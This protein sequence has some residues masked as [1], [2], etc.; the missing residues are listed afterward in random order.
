MGGED[1]LAVTY[2]R[3]VIQKNKELFQ[4]KIKSDIE[5]YDASDDI[6]EAI[7][8]EFAEMSNTLSKLSELFGNK[9]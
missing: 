8:S 6:R 9:R 5:N 4:Q 7:G 2:M 1:S 3:E